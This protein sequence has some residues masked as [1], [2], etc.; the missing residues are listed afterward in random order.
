MFVAFDFGQWACLRG[1]GEVCS[2]ALYEPKEERFSGSSGQGFDGVR[3]PDCKL[4]LLLSSLLLL[5]LLLFLLL[6][7]TCTYMYM[8]VYIYIYNIYCYQ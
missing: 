7:S 3:A 5:L 2:I 8:Y 1:V 6:L 4:L